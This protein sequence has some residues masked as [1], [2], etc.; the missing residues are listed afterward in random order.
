MHF[1]GG[2]GRI[3][4]LGLQRVFEHLSLH[5]IFAHESCSCERWDAMSISQVAIVIFCFK[6]FLL[7]FLLVFFKKSH[8]FL[9]VL[10]DVCEMSADV[11][12]HSE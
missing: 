5:V 3:R 4:V 6:L 7:S 2:G 9:R 12:R 11:I 1:Q 10:A 8:C